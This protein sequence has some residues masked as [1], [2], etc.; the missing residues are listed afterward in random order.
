M[1]QNHDDLR[2]ILSRLGRNSGQRDISSVVGADCPTGF[3]ADPL[4][5][6][7]VLAQKIVDE[8]GKISTIPHWLDVHGYLINDNAS[9]ESAYLTKTDGFSLV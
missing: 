7:I 5:A 2:Q 3:Q 9:S 6:D 8:T 4:V 1:S